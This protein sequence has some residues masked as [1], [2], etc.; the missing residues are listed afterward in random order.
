M[1]KDFPLPSLLLLQKINSGATGITYNDE[2]PMYRRETSL[3]N[4]NVTEKLKC[5]LK[6]NYKH[7]FNLR[8]DV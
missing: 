4:N 3:K 7:M 8:V 2:V 1:I 5:T 6:L